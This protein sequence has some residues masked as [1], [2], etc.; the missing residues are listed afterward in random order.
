M[1]PRPLPK[2]VCQW[3]PD[4]DAENE[5]SLAEIS[6]WI[7]EEFVHGAYRDAYQN[8]D[9]I[10]GEGDEQW[11]NLREFARKDVVDH[12]VIL[13]IG[14]GTARCVVLEEGLSNMVSSLVWIGVELSQDQCRRWRREN[15]DVA[16][17]LWFEPVVA[18]ARWM[19]FRG[20]GMVD[21]VLAAGIVHHFP[22][23]KLRESISSEWMMIAAK[24]VFVSVCRRHP[25]KKF[26]TPDV[27]VGVRG[28][29]ATSEPPVLFYYHLFE[30]HEF[31]EMIERAG[32]VSRRAQRRELHISDSYMSACVRF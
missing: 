10:Q 17:K 1:E 12:T 3:L 19:P 32:N 4:L 27:L 30:D 31:C 25:G 23:R 18:D 8:D 5:D 29:E 9:K 22:G 14:C 24:S 26:P 16:G 28:G 20:G 7:E 6:K 13:D 21:V 2:L 15:P 11:P